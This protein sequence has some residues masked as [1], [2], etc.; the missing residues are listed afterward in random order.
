M[1]QRIL[2]KETITEH[3][4]TI[5]NITRNILILFNWL[6]RLPP[7]S[8]LKVLGYK[9]KKL[10][11]FQEYFF[12]FKHLLSN[13]K[14]KFHKYSIMLQYAIRLSSIILVLMQVKK[15]KKSQNKFI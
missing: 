15:A 8:R 7:F 1:Q 6:T 13:Y 4:F 11:N 3:T 2:C 5:I 12:P 10:P 9:R 14:M